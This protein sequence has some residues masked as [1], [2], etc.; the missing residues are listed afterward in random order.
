M[1]PVALNMLSQTEKSL[2]DDQLKSLG[3]L[4]HICFYALFCAYPPQRTK[5]NQSKCP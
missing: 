3:A 2:T 4:F 5:V 1:A